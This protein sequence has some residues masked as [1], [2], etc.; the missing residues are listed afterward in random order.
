[1]FEADMSNATQIMA[2]VVCQAFPGPHAPAGMVTR[3]AISTI[4]SLHDGEGAVWPYEARGYAQKPGIHKSGKT[5]AMVSSA[6]D[7]MRRAAVYLHHTA[8][9]DCRERWGKKLLKQLGQF[10]EIQV[11][12]KDGSVS[13]SVHG[14]GGSR[15]LN[16]DLAVVFL[17]A[18]W[19][20][21]HIQDD[22]KFWES[23]DAGQLW[24][25]QSHG[26]LVTI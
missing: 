15:D 3:G 7:I 4:A 12:H 11:A 21:L 8:L 13:R 18:A 23:A 5:M 14:K 22:L 19:A 2:N 24:S 20:P 25:Q 1:V 26:F 16:D 17:W 9:S 6:R 10:Q